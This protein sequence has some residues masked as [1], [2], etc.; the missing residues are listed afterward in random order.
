MIIYNGMG[1]PLS[2]VKTHLGDTPL[3]KFNLSFG[4]ERLASLPICPKCE[5]AGFRDKGWGINKSM[6]CTHCGFKGS[7]THVVAAY[8][9]N[10]VYK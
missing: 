6:V 2:T 4:R 1:T 5:R 8:L 3:Q 10:K 9:E 7:A